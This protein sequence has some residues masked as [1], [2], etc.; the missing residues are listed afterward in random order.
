MQGFKTVHLGVG[1]AESESRALELALVGTQI[2]GEIINLDFDYHIQERNEK[3]VILMGPGSRV[4]L[5]PEAI[6]Y[7]WGGRYKASVNIQ[8][9]DSNEIFGERIN[10]KKGELSVLEDRRDKLKVKKSFQDFRSEYFDR[11]G[12]VPIFY[13]NWYPKADTVEATRIVRYL[14]EK[15][16]TVDHPIQV[17]KLMENLGTN[18]KNLNSALHK[19]FNYSP[20]SVDVVET[21]NGHNFITKSVNIFIQNS[22]KAAIYL[23]MMKK[24]RKLP[25]MRNL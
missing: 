5:S 6:P 3:E 11:L 7:N 14:L 17:S 2:L 15:G 18:S 10:Y 23:E 25:H 13:E 8:Y 9:H 16:T 24:L 20:R 19:N 12:K 1:A 4:F 22:E 21:S